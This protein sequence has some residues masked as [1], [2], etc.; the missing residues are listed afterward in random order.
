[1]NLIEQSKACLIAL[2]EETKRMED[3]VPNL[4]RLAS[5]QSEI[6]ECYVKVGQEKACKFNSKE[7]AYLRRK[8]AQAVQFKKGR[9]S[10]KIKSA[11]DAEMEAVSMIE[12]ECQNEIDTATTF[13]EYQA[14]LASLDKGFE[15]ARSII[16]LI[17]TSENR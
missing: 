14:L 15:H 2:V 9:M 17:K 12:T 1:M 11:K 4:Y 6:L 10:E 8:I 3:S 7:S 16:S 13:I 5:L